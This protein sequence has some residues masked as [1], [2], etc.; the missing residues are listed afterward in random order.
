[1][2]ELP[3]ISKDNFLGILSSKEKVS[4]IKNIY[5][6]PKGYHCIIVGD[7]GNNYYLNYK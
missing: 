3:D 7:S 6:D 5:L 4:A 1:M 2:Y